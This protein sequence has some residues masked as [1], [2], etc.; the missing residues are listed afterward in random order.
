[1]Q[2]FTGDAPAD[3]LIAPDWCRKKSEIGKAMR[4][5]FSRRGSRQGSALTDTQAGPAG[6]A[7]LH[8][9]PAF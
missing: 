9:Q 3:M 5:E 7:N 6:G 4:A 1:V 8:A 2:R